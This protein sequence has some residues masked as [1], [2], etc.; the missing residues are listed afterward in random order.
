MDERRL[1][2]FERRVLSLKRSG[3][4]DG[5]I[6]RRFRRTPDFIHRVL[7]M[8]DLPRRSGGTAAEG[9]RPIERRVL[10][11][12]AAGAP[13]EEIAPRFRRSPDFI[14]RVESMARMKEEGL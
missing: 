8:I 2:P 1:R 12:R 7:D 4:D 6:A 3:V 9:L 10:R 11:W 14:R 13:Y 5:E